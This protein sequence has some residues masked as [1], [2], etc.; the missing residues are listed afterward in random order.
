MKT[1]LG[2]ALL[3]L[4]IL[5]SV[6]PA[7]AAVIGQVDTFETGT[8]ESWV[9]GGGPMGTSPPIPPFNDPTGGP[10]G[11]GDAFLHITSQGGMGP[12]SRLTAFSIF[13]QWADNY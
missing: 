6:H 13:S 10:A 9:A 1:K 12:G 4:S 3:A 2:L 8:T 11:A 5:L 7:A